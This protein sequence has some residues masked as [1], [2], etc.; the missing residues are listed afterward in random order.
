MSIQDLSIEELR[1]A[2][3]EKEQ[4]EV[5]KKQ[6][7]KKDHLSR[8]ETF[9]ND[10]CGEFEHVNAT[11]TNL[12]SKTIEGITAIYNEQYA[13]DGKQP[14][15]T[16]SITLK[17]QDGKYK[18]DLERQDRFEFNDEAHVHINSIREIFKNKYEKVNKEM[19]SI[20]D[21]ILVRNGKGDYDAKLLSKARVQVKKLGN[22]ELSEAFEKLQDCLVVTGSAT[23]CRAYRLDDQGKWK[24]ISI[25]F[26][27]L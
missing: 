21:G 1:K 17:S 10:V 8:K 5:S 20:L 14:K 23:Y 18:I 25:Q 13:I 19:Y 2:L 11:L 4:T 16:K 24:D 15:E 7:A 27:S 3:A 9:I 22:A 26:S 6:Q 12:K